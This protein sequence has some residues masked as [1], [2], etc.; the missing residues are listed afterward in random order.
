MIKYQVQCIRVYKSYLSY[1]RILLIN[2][3]K[4][5]MCINKNSCSN[6]N[7]VIRAILE[8]FIQKFHKHKKHE[9]LTA[10]KNKKCS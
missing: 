9:T 7:E 10:N 5:E 2:L 1:K 6:V 4:S 3:L 8:L